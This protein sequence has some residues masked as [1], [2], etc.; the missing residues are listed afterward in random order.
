[1]DTLN[2][3][4]NA[5]IVELSELA[6]IA[7]AH[8]AEGKTIVH[9][10]GVF[11]LVHPG[12]I[13]HLEAAARQGDVLIVTITSD[14]FVNKGPGRPVFNARLRAAT[15]AA[16]E[17]VRY[18]AINNSPTAVDPISIIKP[19]VYVKGS[20]YLDASADVTG[21]ISIE[22]GAVEANGGRIYYTTEA[23]MSS[24]QLLNNYFDVYPP[25]TRQWLNTI[26]KRYSIDEI[27]GWLDKIR[28]TRVLV[29]GEAI[30]DE[31][32]F[33]E[34]LGKSSK[35]P[36]LAFKFGSEEAYVGGSLAVANHLG[37]LCDKVDVVSVV[38]E[39]DN[40]IDFIRDRIAKN[41]NFHP[42][43]RKGAPT[44]HKRRYV[45]SHTGGKLFELYT[46]DDAPVDS[47]T[48][49]KLLGFLKAR[50]VDYDLVVVADYGHGMM[51]SPIIE[52][53][54]KN[55]PFLA[56]NTQVNAGNRGFHTISKYP[57][58]DYVCLNGGEVQLDMRTKDADF[59]AM[60]KAIAKK[61]G[62]RK[63]T[64]TLGKSGTLHYEPNKGF[65][66]APALAIQ[67][68]DRVGAGDAVL[69]ATSPLVLHG[70]PWDIV[71]LYGNL[72][73]AEVVAELGTSRSID[74][75]SLV[76]HVGAMLK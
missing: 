51:S 64:V 67:V 12:H 21:A 54:S 57:H 27:T 46:L 53:L 74:R 49:D 52:F 42:L 1:M 73:G 45:D 47:E 36:I 23:A 48:E 56:A 50:I 35:D 18:V 20:D 10:H 39:R 30:I 26:R 28:N 11:D 63:I 3:R 17:C 58:V 22:I 41:V 60:A 14:R 71:A 8:R 59:R 15:L 70:A 68:T 76:K 65:T 72:A 40:R 43:G 25:E 13:R 75:A 5:K 66:E 19:H 4:S 32:F 44:I 69:A 2:P 31:Y 62:S 29:V 24:S 61:V 9:C 55:S 7:G 38:G 34:G 16:L 6:D 33:C 37:G